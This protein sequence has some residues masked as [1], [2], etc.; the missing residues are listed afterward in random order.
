MALSIKLIFIYL[1]PN[2][3]I[4]SKL[5]KAILIMVAK[6]VVLIKHIFDLN[7]TH[8]SEKMHTVLAKTWKIFDKFKGLDR[9]EIIMLSLIV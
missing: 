4:T 9:P 6:M 8:L 1:I 5:D 3:L 2:Y 7:D